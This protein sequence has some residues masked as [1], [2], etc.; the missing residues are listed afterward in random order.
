MRKFIIGTRQSNLALTQT[1]MVM[2][3][4][5]NTN[6]ENDFQIEEIST[7]GDRR[8]D[9]SL[10]HLGS[11]GAFILDIEQ[12][13]H[14][15]DVDFAVHSMKDLPIKMK[16]E[17]IIA[18]IPKRENPADAYIGRNHVKLNDLPAGAVIGTSSLRRAAQILAVRPDLK[19]KWI[20]G[21]VESRLTQLQNGDFDAII[22]AV[23]GLKRL[24]MDNNVITEQLP[25]DTFVPAAG[26]GAL[27][28]QCR[29][30]DRALQAIL[31]RIND[32]DAYQAVMTERYFVQLLDETDQAPIGAYAY[33][34]G[35]EIT[36]HAT[37]ASMDGTKFLKETT[38]GTGIVK[39][40][41]AAAEKFLMQGAGVII[42]AAKKERNQ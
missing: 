33:T 41:Q 15:G 2:E 36:L 24:G 12:A 34:K 29:K 21:T 25:L 6:V 35:N 42:D 7:E 18:C 27:A 13:L 1:R 4:L 17:F 40:A 3:W 10:A 26:Q 16:E 37:V 38:S 20:R 39:V 19:T 32:F 14:N 8:L 28:I 22:L 30:E 23:A 11:G 31:E 9:V 5:K